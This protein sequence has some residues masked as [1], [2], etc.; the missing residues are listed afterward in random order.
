MSHLVKK[1]EKVSL[2]TITREDL[3]NIFDCFGDW[4][5]RK[6]LN[7]RKE[8]VYFEKEERWYEELVKNSDKDYVFKIVENETNKFVGLIG[9]HN[10]DWFSRKAEL[11]YWLCKEF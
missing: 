1:G 6:F 9:L 7:L 4:E 8:I 11:G 3:R 5:L 2:F 10:V